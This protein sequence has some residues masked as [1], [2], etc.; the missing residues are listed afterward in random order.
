MLAVEREVVVFGWAGQ[1]GSALRVVAGEVLWV[2]ELEARVGA[3][4][5]VE[6]EGQGQDDTLVVEQEFWV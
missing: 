6:V 1:L 3:L 2:W 5:G 4:V